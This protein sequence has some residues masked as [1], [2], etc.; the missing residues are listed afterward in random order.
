MT[1][2]YTR[3][4]APAPRG[5]RGGYRRKK[6]RQ[7]ERRIVE[8]IRVS[9]FATTY[10]L[11]KKLNAFWVFKTVRGLIR[12]GLVERDTA[13]LRLTEKASRLGS[14]D[15]F[16]VPENATQRFTPIAAALPPPVVAP[17]PPPVI[18]FP[19]IKTAYELEH[20][21]KPTPPINSRHLNRVLDALRGEAAREL[22]ELRA[23]PREPEPSPRPV[24]RPRKYPD[25]GLTREQDRS[26]RKRAVRGRTISVKRMTKREIELGRLL[27]PEKVQRPKTRGECQG[28]ARPCPY[29]GCVHHLFLDVSPTTGAIKLNFPDLEPEGMA[30]SCALDVADRDGETLEKVGE[31]LN[32]TRERLRQIEEAALVQ[33]RSFPISEFDEDNDTRTPTRSHQSRVA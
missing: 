11:A 13:G 25:S 8:A 6:L 19:Q 30:E 1:R 33:L 2:A 20:P 12:L 15:P 3:H 18:S 26:R 27:Y 24:G 14:G 7:G 31:C 17:A 28:G 21:P 16:Y 22:D 9:H 32:I 10:Q 23:L 5:P 4:V 29:V